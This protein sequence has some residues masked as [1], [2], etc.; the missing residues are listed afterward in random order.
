MNANAIERTVAQR[1]RLERAPSFLARTASK[2]PIAFTHL[3]SPY[4]LRGRS[5]SVPREADFSFHVPL[6]VPFFSEL[7]IGGNFKGIPPATPG[8]AF[9]FDLGDNPVVSLDT[10]FLSLRFYVSQA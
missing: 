9:L 3:K 2:A 5:V 1:F 8:C 7:W 6:S 10:P 4:A